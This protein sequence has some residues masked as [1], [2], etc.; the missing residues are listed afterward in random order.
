MY[1]CVYCFKLKISPVFVVE[2]NPAQMSLWRFYPAA[3]MNR[4]LDNCKTLQTF[5]FSDTSF[6]FEIRQIIIH[7]MKHTIMVYQDP[8][9]Y[10]L[11]G[12]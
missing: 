10:I 6:T 5:G 4:N 9:T 1:N 3:A 12:I 2:A 8:S 11:K 7:F